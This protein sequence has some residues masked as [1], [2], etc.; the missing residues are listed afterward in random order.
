M[1][2]HCTPYYLLLFALISVCSGL[3]SQDLFID[4]AGERIQSCTDRTMYVSGEKIFFSAVIYHATNPFAEEFSRIFYCELITP[5]GNKIAGG[6]YLLQNS[7]GQ[8]C[9]TIPEETISGIYFLKFYTRF[10]RNISTDE[11][12]Y[13]KLKIINPFKTEVLSGNDAY[14][15]TKLSENN[16]EEVAG[17]Q[18]LIVFS[19]KKT[20]APREEIRLTIKEN[21]GEGLPA[22]LSLSV[23]PEST[24]EDLFSTDRNELNA[25]HNVVYIPET[26]GLSLSGQLIGKESGNPVPYSK[27]NLSIIGDMDILAARTDL[28]G[29]F[30]FA[31]P[32]YNGNKDIFLCAENLPDITPEI[33]IDNDFCS[34][35]VYL[36]SPPF[37]LNEEEMKAAYQLAVNS[38]I[39]SMFREDIMVS[40]SSVEGNNT[41]FYG[42]PS[43]VLLMKKYID[44]PTLEE[45]FSE[46]T[47][48]VNLRKARGRKQFRF[49]TTQ[50]EMSIYDPLVLVDWVAVFDI[51][52]ILAMSPLYIERI[53]LVNSPY[54]KGNITYGGIISFVSKKNDFAGIDLPASGTFVNYSFL[55]ECTEHI[56]LDPSPDNIPESKQV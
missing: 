3:K 50:A 43:E 8:G 44:L 55:E 51:D 5:D 22:R 28:N 37:T 20:Y 7:S 53:E 9:L 14:D 29:K 35:P 36:P 48:M 46:L 17:D 56:P 27:V 32:D 38:R 6:K 31:L 25:A 52:K 2:R 15:T 39:T 45:Y 33:L 34:R 18:S 19:D 54:V 16:M 12:K 49:Y 4:A 13:I 23:I 41:S 24:Y 11:Y 26:R 40:N 1:K 10:M 21:T 30:F 42:E 47:V